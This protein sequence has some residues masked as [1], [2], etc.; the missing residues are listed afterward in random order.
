MDELKDRQAMKDE[1]TLR[2]KSV[3]LEKFLQRRH[4]NCR[5]PRNQ[6]PTSLFR[7]S[8]GKGFKEG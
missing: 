4:I 8:T 6:K 2:K 7:H 5:Q 3:A 1:N